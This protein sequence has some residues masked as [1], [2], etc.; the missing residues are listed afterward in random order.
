MCQLRWM[1]AQVLSEF[2]RRS[3]CTK[4]VWGPSQIDQWL[5]YLVK[6]S[7]QV[8]EKRKKKKREKQK[9]VPVSWNIVRIKQAWHSFPSYLW[10]ECNLITIKAARQSPNL[11][12]YQDLYYWLS[13][14]LIHKKYGAMILVLTWALTQA[15]KNG[16]V[17]ISESLELVRICNCWSDLPLDAY[18]G[19]NSLLC[20][21]QRGLLE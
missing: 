10:G 14:N 2:P 16:G 21:W 11:P 3:L 13:E 19:F 20:L 17:W 4:Y 8:C 15:D 18:T 7:L 5:F 12:F 6:L 1:F 9:W